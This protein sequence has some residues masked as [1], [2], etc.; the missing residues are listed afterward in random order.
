ELRTPIAALGITL[1]VALKKPRTPEQYQRTLADCRDINS[2]LG[3]LVERIMTLAALDAGQGAA[4]RV[5]ADAAEIAAGCATVIKPLA[6]AH[7]L[8]FSAAIARP[9]PVTTDPDKLREVLMN[10]L[11][12]AVE[13]NRP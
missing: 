4:A 12:N 2:Q 13:Y 11:H 6:E 7:G 9:L 5:G 8:A 1:D 10:L 3:K